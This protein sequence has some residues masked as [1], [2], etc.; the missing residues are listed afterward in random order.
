MLKE[1]IGKHSVKVKN[2][3]ERGAIKKFASAIGD[4]HP[5]FIDEEYAK[6]TKYGRNIAPATFPITL[7]YGFIEGL[8]LPG[9]GLIHGEQK[10]NYRRPLYVGEDIFCYREVAN[11]TE[12]KGSSGSLGILQMM[13]YGEDATGETIF[14]SEQVIILTDAVRKGMTV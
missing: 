9:A 4:P 7:D 13:T 1:A 10:F 6:Q 2:T 12:K 14:S 3:V 8:K 11:Y 5:L